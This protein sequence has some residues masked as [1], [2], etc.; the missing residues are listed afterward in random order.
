MTPSMSSKNP[1]CFHRLS[2]FFA[3]SG[4]PSGTTDEGA[5]NRMRS[6][7]GRGPYAST[8]RRKASR[9]E[10]R[11]SDGRL[12]MLMIAAVQG[13]PRSTDVGRHQAGVSAGTSGPTHF[14]E[15]Q[16]YDGGDE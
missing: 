9:T 14:G 15:R 6:E 2:V 11:P 3:R 10:S 5:T 12:R 16:K 13:D 1:S 4:L 7:S 8:A